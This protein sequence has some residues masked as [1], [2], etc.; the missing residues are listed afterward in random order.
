MESNNRWTLHVGSEWDVEPN[1]CDID[2]GP[3]SHLIV[4]W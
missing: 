4:V 3:K 2:F 1:S